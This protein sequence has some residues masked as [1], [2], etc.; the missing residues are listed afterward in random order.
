[1]IVFRPDIVH[2]HTSYRGGFLRDGLIALIAKR[3]GA[4][5]A[6][7]FHPGFG[8]NLQTNYYEGPQWLK[9]LTRFVVPRMDA[10]VA[11]GPSYESFLRAEFGHPN[12][13][14]MPNPVTDEQIPARM[15]DYGSRDRI[16]FFAG[17]LGRRKGVLELLKA[18]ESVPDA[19]FII[20][21][22]AGTPEDRREFQEA[23]ESCKARDR[24]QLDIGY[25]VEKVFQYMDVARVLALPSWGET[26]PLILEEAIVCG[27]PV[28]TTP[29]GVIAD[30]VQDGVHGYLI[31]PGDV[32][33]LADA[34]NRILDDPQKAGQMSEHNR[35]S[36]RQFL[37]SQVHPRLFSMYDQLVAR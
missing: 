21:G 16:V 7:T 3:F 6:L 15:S 18:A 11:N 34:L 5:V 2:V 12:I 32:E 14:V 19:T 33:A 27:L 36:G 9:R 28:V 37:R 8:G 24:I 30:Y 10:L 25:G 22:K 4:R 20:Y 29:V 26:M 31:E 13:H 17:F 23:L 1:M 35:V